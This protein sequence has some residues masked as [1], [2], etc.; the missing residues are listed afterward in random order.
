[1]TAGSNWNG[2]N[3]GWGW[4][5]RGAG[6]GPGKCARRPAQMHARTHAQTQGEGRAGGDSGAGSDPRI[7]SLKQSSVGYPLSLTL[8]HRGNTACFY[9]TARLF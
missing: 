3:E 5:G 2:S 8:P 7:P 6:R 4:A 9:L 1:M